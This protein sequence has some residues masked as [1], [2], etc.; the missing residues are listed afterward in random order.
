VLELVISGLQLIDCHFHLVEL[1][2]VL[3]VHLLLLEHVPLLG[4]LRLL[5]LLLLLDELLLMSLSLLLQ[6]VLELN[7]PVISFGLHPIELVLQ[8]ALAGL[9]LVEPPLQNGS[10]G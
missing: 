8:P 4:E 7:H 9:L 3:S 6:Q 10:C 2:H 1:D 5:N